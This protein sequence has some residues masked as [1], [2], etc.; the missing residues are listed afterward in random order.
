[1][2][3]TSFGGPRIDWVIVGGESGPNARPMHP[4]MMHTKTLAH[5]RELAQAAMDAQGSLAT[6]A[7][8]TDLQDEFMPDFVLD[9]LDYLDRLRGEAD[10]MRRLLRAA[11]DVIETVDGESAAECEALMDLQN[12]IRAA[13]QGSL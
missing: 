2:V 3:S 11:H 4:E 13:Y 8:L 5:L 1:M 9:L 7:T 10:V 12:Q 6:H